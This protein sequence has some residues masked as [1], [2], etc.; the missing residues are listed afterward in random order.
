MWSIDG[1]AGDADDRYDLRKK[2]AKPAAG[3]ESRLGL[4]YHEGLRC[5]HKCLFFITNALCKNDVSVI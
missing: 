3:Q 5:N 2:I 4:K 1:P